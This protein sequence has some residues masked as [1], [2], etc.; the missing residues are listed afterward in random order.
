[1]KNIRVVFCWPE[2][3]GY[4]V[5]CWKELSRKPGV[6]V[7]V[8]AAQPGSLA[9]YSFD[10]KLL[11]GIRCERLS[12]DELK[13]PRKVMAR[14]SGF[15]PHIVYISGWA[16]SGFSRLPDQRELSHVKFIMGMDNQLRASWRQKIAPFVLAPLLRKLAAVAVPG[17]RAWQLAKSWGIAG[18]RIQTGLYGCDYRQFSRAYEK[19]LSAAAWPKRFL[20]VG[21]YVDSKGIDVLMRA[22]E[23]YRKSV[24]DPWSLDLC[25]QGPLKESIAGHEG[26]SD[27]GFI[28]PE[29]LVS[30]MAEHGALVLASRKEPWG[31]ILAEACSAGLPIVCTDACGA[32]VELVRHLSNGFVAASGNVDSFMN[33][34]VWIHRNHSRLSEIGRLGQSFASP[35]SAE[36]W[37]ERWESSLRNLISPIEA[38]AE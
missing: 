7:L 1:M 15:D 11:D 23:G 10:L 37:A 36:S 21:R 2:V 20:Y 38:K 19:R 8:L 17:E 29:N 6:E 18:N 26:V 13:D 3:T 9:D 34:L 28:Q 22:Y 16:I 14:F 12:G 27:L 5:A 25:G 33:G 24:P 32:S 4:M 31:V 30:V 35:F